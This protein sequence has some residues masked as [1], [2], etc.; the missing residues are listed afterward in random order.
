MAVPGRAKDLSN[1]PPTRIGVGDLDLFRDDCTSLAER[2][3]AQGVKVDIKVYPGVPH[4][5]DGTT[6]FSRGEEFRRDEVAFV[7]QF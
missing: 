3:A 5:F 2:L 1:L 7:C 4:G 6:F